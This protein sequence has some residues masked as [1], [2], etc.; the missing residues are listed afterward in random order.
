MGWI[1]KTYGLAP[2]LE[3]ARGENDALPDIF[4]TD[5]PDDEA[6]LHRVLASLRQQFEDAGWSQ[7]LAVARLKR[8]LESRIIFVTADAVSVWP[9]GVRL[10]QDVTPLSDMPGVSNDSSL[11]GSLMVSDKLI[12]LVP[13]GWDVARILST[14]LADENSQTAE[15][16]AELVAGG[17][18][19]ECTGSRGRS[20]VTAEVAMSAFARAALGSQGC[21]Y[22]D[23]ESARIKAAR[24]VGTQPADYLDMLARWY[25]SDA[26]E[27]MSQGNWAD[28]VYASEKY[29]SIMQPKY[30]AA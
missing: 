20:D 5:V 12:S 15:Q 30:Q 2:G 27:A 11:S 24:W 7:P 9:M 1:Q 18:L 23:T 16:F 26:S 19:L 28:A 3:A 10:P 6:R 13:R 21:G 8:G 29:V 25:L 22:L 14:A 17:E 4:I